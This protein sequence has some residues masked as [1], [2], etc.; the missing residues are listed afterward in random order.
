[1]KSGSVVFTPIW[2]SLDNTVGYLTGSKLT[3]YPPQI[4]SKTIDFKNYVVTTSGLQELHRSD[5][6]VF[7]RLNI[8]D[9]TSPLIKLVKKPIELASLVLRKAYYQIR[10]VS[11]NEIIIPFDE[12][13]SST[14]IS[15]DSDGMY[16][17]LDISN[18][19]KERS[20]TID[21]MLVMGGTKKVFKSVS[22]VF[23]VSDTQVN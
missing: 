16:F 4:S 5:E 18:L 2:A 23:K 9:H 21:I 15:S 12:T 22:N 20:Y 13:Y 19:T 17:N 8:F 10:D 3:V 7:V 14:R 1:M 11:T 6:N